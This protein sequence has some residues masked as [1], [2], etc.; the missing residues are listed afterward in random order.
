M[1]A[2]STYLEYIRSKIYA[3][4]VRTAIV[5]AISQ[6][7]DDVNKP[8]LQT[9]AMQAAVQAK[10][11]SGQMAALTI[12]DG[13]LE[14]KKLA[15]KT[16]AT[17]KIADGAVTSAKL[18]EKAVTAE[19]IA[20]GAI[21]KEKLS[22]DITFETDKTL[23]VSDMPADAE[24]VGNAI[25]G[26]KPGLSDRAKVALLTCFEHVAWI[27]THGQDCYEA[28]EAALYEGVIPKSITATYSSFAHTVYPWDSLES[29]RPY[30]TVTAQFDDGTIKNVTNYTLS[31]TLESEVSTITVAYFNRNAQVDIDVLTDSSLVYY[32]PSGTKLDGVTRGFD[33]GIKV[34]DTNKALTILFDV[35]DEEILT[36]I[37]SVILFSDRDNTDKA[38][39]YQFFYQSSQSGDTF[40]KKYGAIGWTSTSTYSNDLP[41]TAHRI[42]CAIVHQEGTSDISVYMNIDGAVIKD[43]ITNP[44]KDMLTEQTIMIGQ[45]PDGGYFWKG[46]INIFGIYFRALSTTEIKNILGVN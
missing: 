30:L 31:G 3:K 10:I 7:Y 32:V 14:G 11:D 4:D 5:N 34:A 36:R 2:I 18:G 38:A 27:D 39:R 15:D 46:T 33:T 41:N 8:A 25:K 19:K 12:A 17:A 43:F 16:I 37:R 35:T 6:C 45:R 44:G 24:A 40:L 28:L 22:D 13:S 21:T 20:N 23:S 9:E 42:K 29:L 26:I 1:S